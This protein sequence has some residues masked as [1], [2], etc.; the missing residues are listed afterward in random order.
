LLNRR[1]IL[2][3]RSRISLNRRVI[4]LNGSR[5]SLNRRLILLNRPRTSLNRRVI[6]L[7]RGPI[8][9]NR[10]L[11]PLN[12]DPVRIN[13]R[14][15]P[16]NRDPIRFNR[17]LTPLNRDPIRINRRLIPLNR[18]PIRVNRGPIALDRGPIRF[19]RRLIPLD[20]DP[21]RFVSAAP[22][23]M[24][25]SPRFFRPL[26]VRDLRRERDIQRAMRAAV[27]YENGGPDVLRYEEVPD[28]P[29]APDGVVVDVEV[30]SVEGGD[31]LHRAATP[32]PKRPHIVGYQCAGTVREV[33]ARVL[34]RKVGD[35]V[36]AIVPNGSHAE[37][38]AAAA[39]STWLLPSSAD[40]AA[41]ACVPVAFGTAHEALFALGGLSK[42]QRV[43]VHAGAGGVGLAA[44][45]LARAAGAE[46]LTTASSD[47]KLTRL[48]DFGAT[49]GINYKT[50]DLVEGVSKAVGPNGVDLVVDTVGGKTLQESVS[51][52]RYKG[53]IV[54]LG[55]AGRDRAPFDPLALWSRNATLIG[56]SLMTSLKNEHARTY[57][58][59]A[60]CIARVARGELR[61]VIDKRFALADAAKAHAY[62]EGRTAF[63]R[64]I[65]LPH[66]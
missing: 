31:T 3:N 48:R 59:I 19:N 45:Q 50:S 32:L 56:M 26:G 55:M 6:P 8:R 9:F 37:R 7:N 39:S 49:H 52:L 65:M 10:R 33:G 28:P 27:Y 30:I 4:L 1:V 64:V 62:I 22:R 63:G 5:T 21:I 12:R 25:L 40:L 34:D 60:E 57:G 46:V 54:N 2:L 14:L 29:C 51:L 24:S 13:R 66:G 23:F 42:G 61:V 16:L 38:V 36:V 53:K 20:R 11:T 47:E 17:R 18:E 58:V 15:I 41:A 44:I 35:R 43:L